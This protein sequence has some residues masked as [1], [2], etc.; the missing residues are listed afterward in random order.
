MAF[1]R[2]P[3]PLFALACSLVPLSVRAESYPHSALHA[4]PF[5]DVRL[6]DEFWAPRI[7]TV[8][9]R[10]VPDLFELGAEKIRNFAIVAGREK[11]K[12]FLAN[13]PD[14]D[15]HKILEDASY[16]LAWQPNAEL[17][18]RL[19]GII[20][21]MAAAQ[22]GDGYLNTQYMLPFDNPASPPRD[23]PHVVKYGYGPELQWHSTVAAWPRGYSQLYVA[24]HLMEA[25][26]A[27]YRATGKARYVEIARKVADN[28]GRHFDQSKPL[29]YADHPEVEI[30][31]M[32]LY[33]ATGEARYLRLADF[34][35]RNSKFHRPPDIGNGENAK[36][37]AEQRNAFGHCVRTMYVYSG[38]TDVVRAFGAA[39]LRAA[40]DSLWQSVAGRKMYVHGGIGNGTAAEQHGL[41]YDLPNE[42]AYS[43]T[44][45]SIAMG[46]WNHRLNLLTGDA[47]YA[48]LV[49]LEAYNSALSGIS[50][51]GTKYFY[52]NRLAVGEKYQ[53]RWRYL[54]CCPSKVPGFVAGI[55][56]WMYATD[57]DAVYVN[58]YAS[59]EG[60]IKLPRGEVTLRQQTRYPW[61]GKV[62]LSVEPESPG[63]FS[64]A[65]R[66]PGWV[67]GKPVPTD[68][69]TF[70]KPLATPFTLTVNGARARY[71]MRNGY[72]RLRRVWKRGDT[73]EIDFPM[74]AR[75][76]RANPLVK[77]D[78]GQ[79]ALR[80]GP[81]VY[82]L[83]AADHQGSVLDIVLPPQTSLR[84]EF[85][86]DLLGGVVVLRG[87]GVRD[88][89]RPVEIT[90]IPYYAWDNRTPGEMT[91]WIPESATP[92]IRKERRRLR[93]AVAGKTNTDG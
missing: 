91:I 34:I 8:Q 86:R 25:A 21:L 1:H 62:K 49:E 7:R 39:D 85:R 47:K 56:R 24:G 88:D 76:V 77:A 23:N 74:A 27:N 26:V 54:F 6:R 61:E 48:D 38:A 59:G 33:E 80:R 22:A 42:K 57:A 40:L 55:G 20:A 18:K 87:R 50:L 79:V 2:L 31:L 4:V 70:S 11:G 10:T 16:S 73:V 60:R 36:P 9:L 93:D 30:G 82:C 13:A 28:I 78:A 35:T 67:R 68:L 66:I 43:E 53:S 71:E 64:I 52:C 72:A 75:R 83:E 81:L 44:C 3:L 65:L 84:P 45:A 89:G 29:D 90:A 41:D 32:K 37:L 14:S 12:I 46:Q 15:I 63:E 69:Y 51:E 5:P 58:L 19:D 92:E 17:E